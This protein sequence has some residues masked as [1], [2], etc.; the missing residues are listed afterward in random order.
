MFKLK[1]VYVDVSSSELLVRREAAF[2]RWSDGFLR[3]EIKM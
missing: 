1:G 3:V 2:Q